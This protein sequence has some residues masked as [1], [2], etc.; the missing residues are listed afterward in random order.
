[1]PLQ[2]LTFFR[3]ILLCIYI[4]FWSKTGT[5]TFTKERSEILGHRPESQTWTLV[6]FISSCFVTGQ[7]RSWSDNSWCSSGS[8]L[9]CVVAKL[10]KKFLTVLLPEPLEICVLMSNGTTLHRGVEEEKKC[11]DQIQVYLAWLYLVSWIFLNTNI[12]IIWVA[13]Q[14]FRIPEYI[15]LHYSL[16][17]H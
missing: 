8:H 15:R 10:E 6:L 1:M 4:K 11:I 7:Q 14:I 9:T 17:G 12:G 3:I 5:A 2:H 13:D 16:R